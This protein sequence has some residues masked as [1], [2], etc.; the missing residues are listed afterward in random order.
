M[1]I[2]DMPLSATEDKVV[3][4]IDIQKALKNGIK[5]LDPGIL[6]RANRNVLYIDEVNLLDAHLVN[7]LLDAAAMGVNV[8]EREGIS[9]FHPSRF[10]LVGTMN[11][12]EGELR[13]QILDRF[14][15]CVEVEAISDREER[16]KIME[17][18][19][20]FDADPWVFEKKFSGEQEKLRLKISRAK[21]ILRDVRI[22][23]DLLAEIVKITTSLGIKTHRADI[24]MEK[25]ARALAALD[26]RL[27][28]TL[29]DVKEAALLA[30]P[31]RI[32]QHPLEKTRRLDNSTIESILKESEVLPDEVF[33]FERKGKLK[34]D[35][36][37]T[38]KLGGNPGMD[39]TRVEGPNGQYIKARKNSN[40]GSVAV[41]ATIKRA[42]METGKLDVQPEHLMEKIR[43]S[44]G[45]VL[46]IILLDSSSSMRLDRK[47]KL[48]KKIAWLLMK[49]SYEKKAK[50][51]LI[52]FRGTRAQLVL[53]PTSDVTRLDSV[54]DVL[55]TGGKTP[56]SDAI[57]KAN[58]LVRK[59]GKTA[60]RVIIISDG[61]GNVFLNNLFDED[62]EYLSSLKWRDA[63]FVIISTENSNRSLGLLEKIAE[64]FE[65]PIHYME[66]LL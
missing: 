44:G 57:L 35:V 23:R 32:K 11:P 50:I 10:I 62:I 42:I 60:S 65:A 64:R 53:P 47:I 30:L 1:Q 63:R 31:H 55:P 27:N 18:K 33:P 16:L 58:E 40:P 4:T 43:V 49:R 9:L 39:S 54:L 29:E 3:G 46:Y 36:F 14:G 37:E 51:A 19:S 61:R 24:V 15:L 34:K 26:G 45:K 41:D 66:E 2:V 8:I 13:P 12:E 28:V 38:I 56:L 22:S 17:S 6:A 20:E 52:V 48:T 7:I 25:T 5:A 59:E 21:E